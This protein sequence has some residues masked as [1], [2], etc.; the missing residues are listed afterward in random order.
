M[1]AA[2]IEK[3]DRGFHPRAI[4]V[5]GDKR[6][7]Y[8]WLNAYK[9]YTG[10]PVY[11]VQI[12][13]NEIPGIEA[14]GIKNFKSLEEIPGPVD[15]AM[16]AVPKRF[17][18][19]IVQDCIKKNVSVVACY[20]S[21]FAE[22]HEEEGIRLQAEV[23]KI[24]R[25]GK[26]EL[27]G[28]NCMGI[29]TLPLNF[30][31]SGWKTNWDT[32]KV[33]PMSAV[34]SM[35]G[36]N[37]AAL[38][39]QFNE[40]GMPV[41]KAVS[42]GNGI[43]LD[44]ADWL[45][46]FSLDPD[47]KIIGMYIEGVSDGRKFFNA[48]KK[49]APLKPV[50]ILKGGQT[51]QGARAASSH[52]GS[53]AS[54]QEIFR[55]ALKQAGAIGVNTPEEAADVAKILMMTRPIRGIRL[56]IIAGAGGP[57]VLVSDA[58][59]RENLQLA[60]FEDRHYDILKNWFTS[61]GNSYRN[62]LDTTGMLTTTDAARRMLDILNEDANVDVMCMDVREFG[63]GGRNVRQE[64][65]EKGM[66][67]LLEEYNRNAK[68]PFVVMQGGS[69]EAYLKYRPLLRDRGV[70]AIFTFAR[71]ALAIRRAYDYYQQLA[72]IKGEVE[73]GAGR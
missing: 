72:V 7:N 11:S 35:S 1:D 41:K 8:Q 39:G 32:S 25:E 9:G 64:D 70:P 33:A 49:V 59:G 43:V 47:V 51:A 18:P 69:E 46:Y 20:T 60:V 73:V 66:F 14:M 13:P 45:E 30:G 2:R 36:A 28:P 42:M 58:I 62:P 26:L 57:S 52:T 38:V 24:A 22:T 65:F 61:T 44:Q 31:Q 63:Q 19:R 37:A 27:V 16:V 3:L 15:Y 53:L 10:G 6:P 67:D 23:Q 34:I 54:S 68:K 56:G 29:G 12:D 4:V 55:T 5:I 17:L 40:H 71:S 50:V 48:L 21:G